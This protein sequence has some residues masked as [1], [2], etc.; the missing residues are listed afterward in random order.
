MREP[1]ALSDRAIADLSFIRKTM[2]GAASFTDVSGRGLVAAGLTALLA[3]AWAHRQP[4]GARWLA[5]WI[6]AAAVAA[7]VSA[8]MM[9]HKMLRRQANAPMLSVPARKFFLGFWP[10]IVAGAVLTAAL[11]EPAMLQAADHAA[12]GTI[13]GL[14]ILLYGVGVITAGA[15]SVRAVPLMGVLFLLLGSVALFTPGLDA[16]LWLAGG[17]GAIHIVS[18]VVI[19]RR[20]GG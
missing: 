1:K 15:F 3:A 8:A 20:H 6:V 13:A 11:V 17:F 14:W 10:A 19:A 4:S 2:E 18:G 5:V 9:R 16:D 7:I 12:F